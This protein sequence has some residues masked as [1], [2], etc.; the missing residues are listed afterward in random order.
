MKRLTP[1]IVI[2]LSLAVT[3]RAQTPAAAL[4]PP[5]DT[6]PATA[7]APAP[8]VLDQAA[9]AYSVTEQPIQQAFFLIGRSYNLA[10]VVEPDIKGNVT[11]DVP[12]GGTVRQLVEA[13]TYPRDLYVEETEGH[14]LVRQQKTVFY[15]LQLPGNSRTSSS[16]TSIALASSSSGSLTSTNGQPATNATVA[17]GV[18][19]TTTGQGTSN[20]GQSNITITESN[21]HPFWDL[22]KA[23][24]AAFALPTEKVIINPNSGIIIVSATPR[25]H[26]FFRDYIAVTN[27]RLSR[28]VDI[29]AQ[30]LEV[31]LNDEHK[32]GIDYTTATAKLGDVTLVGAGLAT[33]ITTVGPAQ[34]SPNTFTA[35]IQAGKVGVFIHALQ[36]QG[37][38]R[39]IAKP[40]VRV[41]NNQ[42][43]YLVVG[44]EQG[45]FTLSAT[46]VITTGQTVATTG[47]ESAVYTKETLTFGTVFSVTAAIPTRDSCILDVK[48]ER[49]TLVRI[50]TSP[51]SRQQTPVTDVQKAGTRLLLRDGETTVLAGLSSSSTAT[52]TRGA[53]G[54]SSVPF[55]GALFRTDAKSNTKSELVIVI[56]A[57]IHAPAPAA[58]LASAAVAAAPA[59]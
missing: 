39:S 17:T 7:S 43:A 47:A 6:T 11:V 19:G 3:A 33:D 45:F 52:A 34:L 42:T 24:F 25:R 16:Q 50:D 10:F 56:T 20:G 18:N 21:E 31:T 27:E 59:K 30:I 23:D 9:S 49:S 29:E 2:A 4:A 26:A 44:R 54:I 57:K 28:Q 8:S 32:L 55:L 51:D 14:V 5:T 40:Q 36:D 22:L 35:N 37:E 13:I 38:V 48:P 1:A 41:M 58:A 53:P 15:E 12:S 46:Q